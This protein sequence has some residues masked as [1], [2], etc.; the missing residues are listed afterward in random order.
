MS[1]F[2][3]PRNSSLQAVE[4]LRHNLADD[5][6][7][8]HLVAKYGVERIRATIE[9][10]ALKRSMESP[11]SEPSENAANPQPTTNSASESES[12]VG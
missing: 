8:E 4:R 1:S 11:A 12:A 9:A 7:L 6:T 3:A 5:Q 10:I 2:P